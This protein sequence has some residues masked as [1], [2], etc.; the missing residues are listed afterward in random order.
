MGATQRL[1]RVL[2][3]RLAKDLMFT[4]RKLSAEEARIAGLV[5][6]IERHYGAA[7]DVEWCYDGSQF[8]IVQSRPITT[9]ATAQRR[10]IEWTRANLREIFPD[11]PLPIVDG[12][13]FLFLIARA[14][15]QAPLVPVGD[16]FLE[17]SLHHHA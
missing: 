5:T 9:G 6:R 1:A 14:L 7:Q 15:S 10:D 8:W 3:K 13:L 11:L 16:P 12:G 2:G 17:E 4:G